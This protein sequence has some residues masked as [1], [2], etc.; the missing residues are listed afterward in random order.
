[1]PLNFIS[2]WANAIHNSCSARFLDS[3]LLSSLAS[4]YNIDSDHLCDECP[5]AKR[6]LQE[7]IDS[8]D[9][10]LDVYSELQPFQLAFPTLVKLLQVA[11]TVVVSTAQCE[12]SFSALARI[13]THLRTRMR[14]ER[15]ADISL[16]SLERD[17]TTRSTL[18][19]DETIQEFQGIDKNRTI[20]LS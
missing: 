19:I 9:T 1:M 2:R 8:L 14:D 6:A 13:K 17:I 20:I 18:F 16:L 10:V 5:L 4:S 15:L 3:S 11:L 12:R 7:K